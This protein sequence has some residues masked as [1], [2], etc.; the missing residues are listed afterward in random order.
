M[1]IVLDT[2]IVVS[3]LLWRGANYRLL[4]AIRSASDALLVAS[5]PLIEELADVLDRP[6]CASRYA[7]IGKTPA[8]VI[9]DYLEAVALVEPANITPRSVDPDDDMVLATALAGAADLIV[10]GDAD[11][12]DLK[13]F[14][15]IDIVGIDEAIRRIERAA[16]STK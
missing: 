2:N 10:S 15:G 5:A 16:Q 3:A 8:Q 4:E 9:A 7:L 11:L 1:R 14:H 6:H 13:H 12:L